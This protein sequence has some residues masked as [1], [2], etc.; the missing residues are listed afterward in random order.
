MN[1]ATQD[2]LSASVQVLPLP[3]GLYLFSV[4]SVDKAPPP[5]DGQLRLPAMHVGLGPGVRA[6]QVEFVAGPAT[7]GA[8][9]FAHDDLLVTKVNGHGA[10]LVLTSIRGSGGEVLSI[11]VE[12]LDT[13]AD[14][15]AAMR[16]PDSANEPAVAARANG[17]GHGVPAPRRS[18]ANGGLP[19]L[20]RHRAA[21]LPPELHRCR[22]GR[23]RR[24]GALDRVVLGASARALRR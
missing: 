8:W 2:G 18:G 14:L 24:A 5:V 13:R 11:K 4:K 12:R 20:G 19:L 1:T 10:T 6:E 7:N 9:L 3:P 16:S 21:D 22:L 17:N 15:L 23:A